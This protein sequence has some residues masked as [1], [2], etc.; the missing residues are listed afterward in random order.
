MCTYYAF[1]YF[2]VNMCTRVANHVIIN[3]R[4]MLHYEARVRDTVAVEKLRR[5]R[6]SHPTS[7][8]RFV[9]PRHYYTVSPLTSLYHT[10]IVVVVVVTRVQQ[11]SPTAQLCSSNNKQWTSSSFPFFCITRRE[12]PTRGLSRT[13]YVLRTRTNKR[14][15]TWSSY[16]VH[17]C[18]HVGARVFI[19]VNV[20]ENV[21]FNYG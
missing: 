15:N 13:H 20:Y 19:R 11:Q 6:M 14:L 5:H 7:M 2:T 16:V 3:V 1:I 8:R 21:W 18:M 4:T 12:S 17:V 9:L 10:F